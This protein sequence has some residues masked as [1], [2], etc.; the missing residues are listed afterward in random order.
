[1]YNV[2]AI[3][4]LADNF[5]YI[6]DN[7]AAA[8]V[9]DPG[10]ASPVLRRL[11]ER[12]LNLT[13]ILAT[14]AH[15][16]HTG[17]ANELV[18]NSRCEVVGVVEGTSG[19]GFTYEVGPFSFVVLSTPGHSAD[20]VCYYLPGSDKHPGVVFTGDTLFVGGCGRVF[21]RSPEAMW[22]S[23]QLLAALPPETRVYC[24]HDYSLEDY[25]FAVTIEPNNA[26]VKSRLEEIRSLVESGGLTV[27]STIGQ[28]L[29]TNPF[30]RA[31]TQEMKQALGMPD[32]GDAE[33]FAAL[34]RLKDRF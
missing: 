17:G 15:F 21:T 5:T 29:A 18:R 20:S 9:I 23:L 11:D 28:E 6:V 30:L 8:V 24:G 2:T 1:M 4:T 16:D 27:P 26:E 14:H 32:A 3:A 25:E 7:G 13:A 10:E 34:R 19:A 12:S 31:S 22:S 33:T